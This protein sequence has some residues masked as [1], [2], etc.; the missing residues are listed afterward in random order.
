MSLQIHVFREHG[1]RIIG[2]GSVCFHSFEFDPPPFQLVT[3]LLGLSFISRFA[4][5]LMGR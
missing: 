5:V 4:A 1:V 2:E 3:A